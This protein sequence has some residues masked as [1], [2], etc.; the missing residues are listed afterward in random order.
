MVQ[1]GDLGTHTREKEHWKG[2][3]DRRNMI[4]GVIV[5]PYIL[6]FVSIYDPC[7]V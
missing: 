6:N 3:T 2:R 1:Y 7:H 5:S 4:S